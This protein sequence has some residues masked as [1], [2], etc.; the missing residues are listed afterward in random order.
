M[1]ELIAV[2]LTLVV[3]GC[4][5]QPY[6]PAPMPVGVAGEP[7]E[8]NEVVCRM[9]RPTGSNRPVK[10]CRAASGP[11]DDEQTTRDMRVLQRQTELLNK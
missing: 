7:N 5:G 10:V 4:A 11:L 6:S 2:F 3:S 8:P 1:K 9:E